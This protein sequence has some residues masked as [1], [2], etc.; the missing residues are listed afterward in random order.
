MNKLRVVLVAPEHDLN[1]GAV[2]RVMKNFGVTDLALVKP[3]APIGFEA[4]KYAKHSQEVLLKAP[5]FGSLFEAVEGFDF[6]VATSGVPERYGGRLKN[7]ITLENLPIL[8]E[9]RAST[10]LVFGSESTGLSQ[11]DLNQCD[12]CCTIPTSKM[13]HILNLSH[14]VGV[15]M[16]E[17]FRYNLLSKPGFAP[18]TIQPKL[19]N[20]K[21]ASRPN[22]Q[23]LEKLFTELVESLPSVRDPQKVSA[24]L[25]NMVER[26]KA[27]DEEVRSLM[28]ALSPLHSNRQLLNGGS[29]VAKNRKT[30]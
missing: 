19:L 25:R 22:R 3:V 16:Y 15:V 17:I 2:A 21:A 29:T 6:V 24:S 20:R 12:A 28:A 4:Q 26:S 23:S 27:T 30:P 1:V 18:K 5:R 11:S 10:A 7:S 13:H 9:K 8:M 14:S